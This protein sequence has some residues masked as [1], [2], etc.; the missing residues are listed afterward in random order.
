ME[1]KFLTVLSA[2]G[3]FFIIFSIVAR[4]C[5]RVE[6]PV[7]E[8]VTIFRLNDSIRNVMSDIPEL[9]GLDSRI[10]KYLKRW[11]MKGGSLAIT[12]GDSLVYAKGYGWAD[13]ELG[14]PMEPGH[15]LR[16]A[17]V[18]KLITATGI[19]VL[20][21]RDSLSIRDTVF[22]PRGILNDSIFTSLVRYR[23]YKKITVEHLLRHQAGFGRDP[24]FS[25]R[26][27][28]HQLR[29]D[30]TPVA[31]DFY[32][33]VL[34]RPLRFKPGSWQQYSNLGYLLLSEIIE[35]VSGMPYEEFIRKEVLEPAGCFDMHIAGNYYEDKRPN[36]VRYY[37]HEGDGKYIEDYT[38]NGVMVERSYGG[39]NIPLLQGAGAW[40]GS[41]IEIARLVASIDG[42]PEVPDIISPEAVAEMT[43]YYDRDT[44]SLGWND[45]HP[46]KGWTRTGTLSG[47]CALV[48][49]Y[50]DGECWILI[51]NTST[52]RGPSQSRYTESLFRQ[53]RELYSPLLPKRNLFDGI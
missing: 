38:D 40:C 15:I 29:L 44:F 41:P 43:G 7:E 16:M 47:T 18:S 4:H 31:E 19:M 51:T 5:S 26:D 32:S 45:T 36:E 46:D 23:D 8:E 50:P 42:S 35:K 2:I 34:N 33:V 20:Q 53:C 12:R 11:Q 30:H 13:E 39:N 9:E 10:E 25:S 17:S 1:K 52:W 37:T 24:L 3:L 27:V 6:M 28:K 21:D 14:I 48:H 22:G 49:R